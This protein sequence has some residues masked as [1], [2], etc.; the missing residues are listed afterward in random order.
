MSTRFLYASGK[1]FDAVV[2]VDADGR[3]EPRKLSSLI[4]GLE[5]VDI[6]I[7][8]RFAGSSQYSM[9]WIRRL[10]ERLLSRVV[11]IHGRT[12][13]TNATS[14]GRAGGPCAISVF[15]THYP[16][17]YL[18]DTVESLVL[19]GKV[20]LTVKEVPVTMSARRGGR[21]SQTNMFGALYLLRAIFLVL[22]P[23]VCR[24]PTTIEVK[25]AH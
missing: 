25:E 3:H 17:E 6:V 18:G 2:Q 19:A 4:E 23:F 12:T 13:I 8:S 16:S 10:S 20:G 14:G 1:G 15:A 21:P 9:S 22:H 5:T 7:G 24:A 11:S